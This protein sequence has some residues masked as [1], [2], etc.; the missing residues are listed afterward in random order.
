MRVSVE[1]AAH[2]IPEAGA[3]REQQHE[4]E[5]GEEEAS[6][7][8]LPRLS[9]DV[10][11]LIAVLSCQK[12]GLKG[13]CR[14]WRGVSRR[15]APPECRTGHGGRSERAAH[16]RVVRAHVRAHASAHAALP[17]RHRLPCSL[18]LA[19]SCCMVPTAVCAP[20]GARRAQLR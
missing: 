9:D 13:W 1:E 20:V 16:S 2:V 12:T 7:L 17:T 15:F 8:L 19:G 10:V 18:V 14:T 5:E 4:E 3:M 11:H 6:P